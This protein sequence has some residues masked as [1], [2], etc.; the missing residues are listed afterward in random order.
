MKSGMK[1][2]M[3]NEMNREM[4]RAEKNAMKIVILDGYTANPGDLSWD[5]LEA[6]GDLTVYVRTSY[7]DVAE[8]L[9]RIGDA[10]AV[11]TNKTPL[12]AEVINRAPKLR[13]I[14]VLA[15]GYN[16]VDVKAAAARDI[17]VTNIPAYSTDSVAQLTIA[18]LLEIC[19]HVGEH[20]R[21]V[22][23]GRWENSKDFAFW[24]YPLIELKGKTFGVVGY[25]QTGR[26]TAKIAKALGMNIIAYSRSLTPGEGDEVAGFRALAELYREADVI[27][28]HT[29]LTQETEGMINRESIA[30]M[31]DGV[32][33]L[34]TSRGPVVNE[35]D[36]ADALDSGKVRAAAV[37]V[38][39]AEP[40]KSDNPLLKA[41]NIIITPHI[42]WA[43]YEARTRL[44]A[45]AVEN[46]RAFVAGEPVNVVS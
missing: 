46:L 20:S 19:H 35:Q 2:D 13:Y 37:D 25:G 38:V 18:L 44:I 27:S 1:S 33:F 6:M 45:I 29:P 14:G 28:M 24:D 31:K 41:K 22:L 39:S 36:L 15:T 9:G 8:I 11:F 40:I 10:E 7:D 5:G 4:K 26:A 34:N 32:I 12:S 43:P 23:S 17:V 30:Q 21:A 16:V 3:K 42:A